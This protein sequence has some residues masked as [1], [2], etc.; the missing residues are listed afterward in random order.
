VRRASWSDAREAGGDCGPSYT[1]GEERA[2]EAERLQ[3]YEERL[4]KGRNAREEAAVRAEIDLVRGRWTRTDDLKQVGEQATRT[5]LKVDDLQ[6]RSRRRRRRSRSGASRAAAARA[7]RRRAGAAARAAREPR[8][9]AGP[10]EPRLY[11]RVRSGRIAPALAPLTDE[12]ACGNCF[13]ILPVQEQTE[14]VRAVRRCTAA[15]AAA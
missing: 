4:M 1:A 5:D 6:R 2:A 11:E 3:S 9:P 12:G 15:R 7:A 14:V 8:R 10:A 13:N